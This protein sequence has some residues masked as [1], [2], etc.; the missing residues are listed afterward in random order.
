MYEAR[1]E[2]AEKLKQTKSQMAVESEATER[3]LRDDL[4]E[5][6]EEIAKYKALIKYVEQRYNTILKDEEQD[7]DVEISGLMDQATRNLQESQFKVN[8]LKKEQE[9]LLRGLTAMEK[10][11]QKFAILQKEHEEN[12]GRMAKEATALEQNI[13][14]LKSSILDQEKIAKKK[15]QDIAELKKTVEKTEKHKNA[16]EVE[17]K[18]LNERIH[19]KEQKI[20]ELSSHLA[21]AGREFVQKLKVEQNREKQIDIQHQVEAVKQVAKEKEDKEKYIARFQR[22]LYTAAHESDEPKKAIISLRKLCWCRAAKAPILYLIT[23]SGTHSS[24]SSG[25][26]VAAGDGPGDAGIEEMD[27]QKRQLS[28]SLKKLSTKSEQQTELGKANNLRKIG[29]NSMLIAEINQ[30]RKTQKGYQ[31]KIKQMEVELK[32]AK[33]DGA[34]ASAAAASA[35]RTD[36]A[37]GGSLGSSDAGRNRMP[38]IGGGVGGAKQSYKQHGGQQLPNAKAKEQL[39]EFAAADGFP[40][41]ISMQNR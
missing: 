37:G 9:T 21:D 7:R 36:R 17:L 38:D 10:E 8:A 31:D 14:R 12:A 3:S 39:Q 5:K 27:R 23:Y 19:P 32:A 29:E 34:P 2:A 35:G 20:N 16:V 4:S 28:R 25:S 18:F 30:L 40:L 13:E 41:M 24:G 1:E 33:M 11:R 15:E 26:A 22:E 6:Q